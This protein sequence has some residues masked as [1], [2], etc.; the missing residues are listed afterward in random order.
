MEKI[1]LFILNGISYLVIFVG[2]LAII[3]SLLTLLD[4]LITAIIKRIKIYPLLLE[5]TINYVRKKKKK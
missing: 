3:L 2:I 4:M 5:F 1:Y